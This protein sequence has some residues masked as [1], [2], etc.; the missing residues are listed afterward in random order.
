M[1]FHAKP[2]DKRYYDA[3]V[4]REVQFDSPWSISIIDA[5]D[6]ANEMHEQVVKE[7]TDKLEKGY[8]I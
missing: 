6:A 7:I 8:P 3:D 1:A 2:K 4:T 5:D